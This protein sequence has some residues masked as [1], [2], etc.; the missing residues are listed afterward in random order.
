MYF[1]TFITLSGNP[2]VN[3]NM[4]V[5]ERVV[6]IDHILLVDDSISNRKMTG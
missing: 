1:I 6:G 5:H 3:E 2:L 4:V